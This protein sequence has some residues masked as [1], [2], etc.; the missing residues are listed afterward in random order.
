MAWVKGKLA[1]KWFDNL[2]ELK[3]QV[4]EVLIQTSTTFLASITGKTLLSAH[5]DYLAY[6]YFYKV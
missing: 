6:N 4:A 5:L 2:D 3:P 1:W